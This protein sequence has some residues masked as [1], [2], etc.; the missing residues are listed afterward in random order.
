MH[1]PPV[2][3]LTDQ[4]VSC[5]KRFK[6]Q[7]ECLTSRWKGREWR[8]VQILHSKIQTAQTVVHHRFKNVI[9]KLKST[10]LSMD[11]R[12]LIKRSKLN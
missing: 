12:Q 4:L 9:Y 10:C 11:D 2:V 8:S 1:L 7:F 6:Q 3:Q 5:Y